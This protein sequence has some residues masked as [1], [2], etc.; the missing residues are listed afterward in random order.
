M[1]SLKTSI[2]LDVLKHCKHDKDASSNVEKAGDV[3]L[4]LD[5]SIGKRV[6]KVQGAIAAS[7]YIKLPKKGNASLGLESRY[8]YIQLKPAARKLYAIHIDIG[9]KYQN[10]NVEV[11]RFSISSMYKGVEASKHGSNLQ[12]PLQLSPQWAVIA[13]DVKALLVSFLCF[14]ISF[15]KLQL[16]T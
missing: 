9:V 2:L 14:F 5:K 15:Y 1:S 6:W 13:I 4:V 12:I 7:N 10:G 3:E 16:I 8:I 11:I